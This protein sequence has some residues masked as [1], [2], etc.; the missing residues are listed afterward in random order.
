MNNSGRSGLLIFQLAFLSVLFF[1]IVTLLPGFRSAETPIQICAS[2]LN[3]VTSIAALYAIQR[4]KRIAWQ[5]GWLV[6]GLYFSEWLAL[7]IPRT[8]RL[9]NQQ[10]WIAFSAFLIGGCAVAFYWAYRWKKTKSYFIHEQ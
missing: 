8:L 9:P 7:S 6:L 1:S 2:A 4:R 3:A 5:L 10:R